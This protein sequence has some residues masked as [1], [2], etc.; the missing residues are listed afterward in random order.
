MY[1]EYPD[2]D[3][4][5]LRITD[6]PTGMDSSFLVGVPRVTCFQS[7]PLKKNVFVVPLVLIWTVSATVALAPEV[8]EEIELMLKEANVLS[9]GQY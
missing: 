9:T 8:H 6:E 3:P 5:W 1:T 4:F 7:V 2:A